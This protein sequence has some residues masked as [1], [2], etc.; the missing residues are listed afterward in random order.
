MFD[1]SSNIL[2]HDDN[3]VRKK[4]NFPAKI[5]FSDIFY[6]EVNYGSC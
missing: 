2:T 6:D 1:F 5:D 3:H 4:E